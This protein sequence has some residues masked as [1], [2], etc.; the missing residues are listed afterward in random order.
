MARV[1]RF[2]RPTLWVESSRDWNGRHYVAWK[3]H[4][5]QGFSDRRSLLRWIGWPPKTQ[6]GDELR[7]WLDELEA[8]PTPAPS[9]PVGDANVESSFD[10]LAHGLDESD[11]Q[12]AT[13][14]VI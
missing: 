12:H 13:R 10:P 1:T 8:A 6:T 11:P 3:P 5:S 9:T 7:A 14:T 4:T 2:T